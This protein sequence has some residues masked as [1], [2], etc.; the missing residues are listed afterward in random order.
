MFPTYSNMQSSVCLIGPIWKKEGRCETDP[1]FVEQNCRFT[2]GLCTRA[3]GKTP[4][5][6]GKKLPVKL[7]V[8]P[9]SLAAE[10]SSVDATSAHRRYLGG[11]LPDAAENSCALKVRQ[12][13]Y[14]LEYHYFSLVRVGF[15]VLTGLLSVLQGTPNGQLMDVMRIEQTDAL[16][17]QGKVPSIVLRIGL[18]LTGP[19][20]LCF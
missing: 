4:A 16:V 14:V 18:R 1:E 5:G 19:V 15:N 6:G 7:S 17:A 13:L 3:D 12:G 10:E 8:P 20:L 11:Q 9:K 2:C